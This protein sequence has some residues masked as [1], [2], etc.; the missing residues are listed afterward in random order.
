M[1]QTDPLNPHAMD[2]PLQNILHLYGEADGPVPTGDSDAQALQEARF[3]MDHRPRVRP[4]SATLDAIFAASEQAHA[5][6]PGVRRPD[7]GP[8]A[9]R[10]TRRASVLVGLAL[11]LAAAVAVVPTLM[12]Q[13]TPDQ[14]DPQ[15]VAERVHESPLPVTL[16]AVSIEAEVLAPAEAPP[17]PVQK[18]AAVLAWEGDRAH[19][20]AVARKAAD[21]R[22]RL[23]STLWDASGADLSLQGR[24]RPGAFT[25]ANAGGQ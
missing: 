22:A 9:H 15:P 6:T 17:E 1:M 14:S 19:L 11:S 2:Q 10:K 7:R 21:L 4:D 24:G 5:V 23:D 3:W 25:E 18:P 8:V 20:D 13:V 16:E 12:P